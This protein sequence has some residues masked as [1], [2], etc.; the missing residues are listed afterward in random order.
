[1]TDTKLSALGVLNSLSGSDKIYAVSGGVSY[2][3]TVD[4]LLSYSR[5]NMYPQVA[6]YADLPVSTGSG[7]IYIVQ[8]STGVWPLRK[9][10]GFWRDTGTGWAWLGNATWVA[11][12]IGFTPTGNIAATDVAGALA[13]LDSEK[14]VAAS[15]AAVATSG[16]AADLSG[17]LSSAQLPSNQK[18]RVVTFV[19]DGGGSAITTGLKGFLYIPFACT[20][21]EADLLADQSGSVVVN[22]WKTSYASFDAGATHPVAADKI[23]A[24]APP[25]ISAATKAQDGTLTGWTTS[26]SAGDILAFNVDSAATI[27]RV[28]IA[29]KVAVS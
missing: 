26:L 18:T 22:V 11:G 6:T 12:E 20:I 21:T 23:T 15:L 9:Y 19:I 16:S 10:A 28:T 27:Q 4:T 29:L 2:G 7:N 1:M 5:A 13:E 17:T 8:G 25:T 24:S 3:L 14:A